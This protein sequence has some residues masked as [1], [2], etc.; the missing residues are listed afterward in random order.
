M[1]FRRGTLAGVTALFI[2][3]APAGAQYQS[4]NG[5]DVI[6]ERSAAARPVADYVIHVDPAD[7]T[8]FGVS[9]HVGNVPDTFRVAMAAHPE[10]DDAYW[11]Y[12]ADLHAESPRGTASITPVDHGLWRVVTTGGDVTIRYRLVLP[13]Q[14]GGRYA[15]RPFVSRSG[16][17][18]GDIHSLMYVVGATQAPAHVT[19]D[20]PA[21]WTIATGL[22]PGAQPRTFIAPNA[23]A[24]LDSP[25]LAGHVAEWRFTVDG[26][27]H[28]VVYWPAP[29]AAVFDTAA[30]VGG[31]ERI[32]QQAVALFGDAPYRDYTF[33]FRD[34]AFG[35]L[36]HANSVTIGIPAADLARD[37]ASYF[38]EIAHEYFHAWNMIRI[39]PAEFGDV[40][41]R[42][43][44]RSS[45]LWWSEGA[46][47]FYADLL[48]RRAGLE[49]EDS[50]RVSHLERLLGEYFSTSGNTT[51]SPE[52]VS[53]A[54]YG[55]QETQ[56][57]DNTAST[58]L[59]G[60]LITAALD[61][62]IRNAT[63]GARSI[64]DVMRAMLAHHSGAPGFT[65]DDVAREAAAVCG[66]DMTRFFAE[67]VHGD[68]PVEMNRYLAFLGLVSRTEWEPA[69][70]ADG[71]RQPDLRF[72]AW[73]P[74]SGGGLRLYVLDTASVWEHAG[75]HT[76]DRLVS[77]DDRPVDTVADFAAMV[78]ALRIGDSVRV[79]VRRP[80]GNYRTTVVVTGYRRAVV[81]ITEQPGA[82][83]A[84]R[85]LRRAWLAGR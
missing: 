20:V 40:S 4:A 3:A 19:V 17:M 35:S 63:A 76:G 80:A 75:L 58:H 52:R 41:Y 42:T 81:T 34:S 26:V 5:T 39:R 61:L 1:T 31:I 43:P 67:H 29:R 33:L 55:P 7:T 18:V 54:A 25:I 23:S 13:A 46:T 70:N 44:A 84:Q 21:D 6:E 72:Y 66:C 10:Y 49:T 15:Y 82:T 27:P 69:R 68:R 28:R 14:P 78:H 48:T 12:L 85:A 79:V 71:T 9:M 62:T 53:R 16:A 30:F 56:L 57:G 60:E 32:V 38:E 24:L 11:R 73:K 45:A 37:P 74:D 59:Q 51:L 2:A 22:E 83:P 47:M 77:L 65:S 64:D 8:G 36:E 50:T